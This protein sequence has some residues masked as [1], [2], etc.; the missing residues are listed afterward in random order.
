[1]QGFRLAMNGRIVLPDNRVS[2]TRHKS[3]QQKVEDGA[4][5]IEPER[6]NISLPPAG[7]ELPG[8]ASRTEEQGRNRG[9]ELPVGVELIG[10][11]MAEC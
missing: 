7:H 10:D 11:Q 4:E 9:K 1:M 2:Q 6:I 3:A 5:N 8:Q